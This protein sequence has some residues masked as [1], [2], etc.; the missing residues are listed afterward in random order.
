[1]RDYKATTQ[2]PIR[3][4]RI[5]VALPE[6]RIAIE[7]DGKAYHSSLKQKTHDRKR[8]KYLESKRW[9]TLRFSG[10]DINVNMSK[11]INRIESEIQ[12]KHSI[13]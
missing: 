8:D 7:C 12:K 2:Y 3:R 10:K 13:T 6:Y 1:M 11:V 4:Y 5:D 9:V